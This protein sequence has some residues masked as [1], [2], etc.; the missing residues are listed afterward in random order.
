MSEKNSSTK[1]KL[2]LDKKITKMKF[3]LDRRKKDVRK[4]PPQ[5]TDFSYYVDTLAKKSGFSIKKCERLTT[6]YSN[7]ADSVLQEKDDFDIHYVL[8]RYEYPQKKVC[9]N[10]M[11]L[12]GNEYSDMDAGG[13]QLM[14]KIGS[15]SIPVLEGEN[16]T[17]GTGDIYQFG[18]RKFLYMRGFYEVLPI[19]WGTNKEIDV[20]ATLKKISS[21]SLPLEINYYK[22]NKTDT[23]INEIRI[24]CA[25][26]SNKLRNIIVSKDD[27]KNEV[28][29]INNLY[30]EKQINEEE[31]IAKLTSIRDSLKEKFDIINGN[32]TL[33]DVIDHPRQYKNEIGIL[34]SS[35]L[36]KLKSIG[37]KELLNLFRR[38]TYSESIRAYD[39]Y[40]NST[41]GMI[42]KVEKY[43]E[44]NT[45]V[46]SNLKEFAKIINRD[47]LTAND[48]DNAFNFLNE[49]FAINDAIHKA[50]EEEKEEN[51]DHI[52]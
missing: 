34:I 46:V 8:T 26:L 16:V 17:I 29:R 11:F 13:F 18:T 39:N 4:I 27:I 28:D 52:I 30:Q 31:Y 49:K 19:V 41:E 37:N 15:M 43:D 6:K 7:I 32:L 47:N 48:I 2:F 5:E 24:Y 36:D 50:N 51:Q 42:D 23:L 45:R 33:T 40:N 38:Y 25:E 35:I 10:Y 20:A 44:T 12:L 9:D 14:F 22:F 21:P 3:Y 1:I